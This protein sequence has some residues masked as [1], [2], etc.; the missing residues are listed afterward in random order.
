MVYL[1]KAFGS[2]NVE[3]EDT[4]AYRR[5]QAAYAARQLPGSTDKD[6]VHDLRGASVGAEVD[7]R[8]GLAQSGLTTV[9]TPLDRRISLSALSL[10][11]AL[12]PFI[13]GTLATMLSSFWTSVF[14]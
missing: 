12:L 11:T 10:H 13:S 6:Y 1:Q 4:R 3:A 9:G 8:R 7:S 14:A 5:A 2:P